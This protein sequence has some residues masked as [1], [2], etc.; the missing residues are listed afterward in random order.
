M[1]LPQG[2]ITWDLHIVALSYVVAF[3]M[4][5]AGCMLMVHMDSHFGQQMIFSTTAAIG[6]CSM[7]YTGT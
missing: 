2:R 5:F 6:C 7:H 1:E 4:C 3:F